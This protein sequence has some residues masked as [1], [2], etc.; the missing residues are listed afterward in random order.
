MPL[1]V[2]A[3]RG[4]HTDRHT[5]THAY[6]HVNQSNFKKPGARGQRPCA[7]GLK[8]WSPGHSGT[9]SYGKETGKPAG[10]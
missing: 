7:P 8:N 10:R 3:L 6:R 2:N 4:R 1:V 9:G 5:D